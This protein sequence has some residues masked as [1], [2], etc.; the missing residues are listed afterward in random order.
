MSGPGND[1]SRS[2]IGKALGRGLLLA[3]CVGLTQ[4]ALGAGIGWS[5]IDPAQVVPLEQIP[6]EFREP[7]SEVIRDHTFHRKGAAESFPCDPS[8][9]L[10]LVNEPA[11]TLALWKD[12]AES[13]VKIKRLGPDTYQ[14]DDG[15]GSSAAWQFLVR[16]PKVH[17]MLA[18]LNF[19]S[20]RGNTRVDARVVLVV[21][22]GYYR[23]VNKEAYVQHDVEAFVKVDSKG[24]KTLART[25]R[26][27]I[28]RM[29]EDQVTEAGQFVSLMSKLVVNY[30]TWATQVA[31][32]EPEA[33][34][35]TR[36][37]FRDL[38]AQNRRPD[39]SDGRPVVMADASQAADTRR[40]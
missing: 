39:A 2:G 22:T 18:N 27:V 29:L 4:A 37:Q 10:A 38:V 24:W 33:T 19:V 17:V 28:E 21:H 7:V 9:Y 12:L 30:P 15:A 11:I 25:L 3:L 8:L 6:A 32:R 40:R 26:P 31:V 16:S 20:P 5:K 1:R 34:P 23:E 35:E 13:P 36:A 14:G